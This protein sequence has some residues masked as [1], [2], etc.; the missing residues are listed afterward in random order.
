VGRLLRIFI[1]REEMTNSAGEYVLGTPE[2]IINPILSNP[3]QEKVSM[4]EGCLSL[5]GLYLEVIRP[6]K[7]HIRYMNL[8]GEWLEEDL[9]AFRARV[10]MHEN[11]HLNGVLTIDRVDKK[12]RKA[13][14]PNLFA[15][16]KKFH[17]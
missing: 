9:D 5:P 16:K 12:K 7:I 14:E 6:K 15:I 11:D 3:S 8:K 2:V 1:I 13:I 10:T 17:P 4:V